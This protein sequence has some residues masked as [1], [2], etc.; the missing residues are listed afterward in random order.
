MATTTVDE[1]VTRPV[2][3]PLPDTGL[4]AWIKTTDHKKIGILY[5][6][7]S[8]VFFLVGGIEALIMRLQL[9]T[10]DAHVVSPN[11]YNQLFTMHGVTMIFLVVMPILVGYANFFL[12]LQIGARDIA[13]PRLNAMSYWLFLF[14]GLLLYFSIIAG[15]MP[16]VG[17]FAYANLWEHPYTMDAG[18][19]F[20]A[21]SLIVLGAG[22]IATALNLIV[23]V[24]AL[25]CPGM[26]LN[27]LPLFC[28][29]VIV[30]SFLIIWALPFLTADSILLLFDRFLGTH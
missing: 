16:Q 19:V 4:L 3:E 29:M 1:I 11:I 13:F 24:A 21:A 7:T 17:W 12:P 28:W 22:S 30:Q 6:A 5:I 8:L 15:S 10:P 9:A 23:T 2:Q 26:T 18:P 27:R 20:W 25:R 14:G